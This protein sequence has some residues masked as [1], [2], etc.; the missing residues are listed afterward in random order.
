MANEII[1]GKQDSIEV[2]QNAKGEFS[3]STKIY[4]D[5]DKTDPKAVI[6]KI[7]L[8]YLELQERFK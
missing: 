2:N 1:Q 3:Y 6:D 8:I 4:Y 7:K 5:A